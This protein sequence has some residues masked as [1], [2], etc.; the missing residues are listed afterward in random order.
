VDLNETEKALPDL[1]TA[2]KVSTEWQLDFNC[3]FDS[4]K[5][6]VLYGSCL[7]SHDQIAYFLA[8]R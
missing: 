7:L 5:N 2:L 3:N 4:R 8:Q 6:L 1:H